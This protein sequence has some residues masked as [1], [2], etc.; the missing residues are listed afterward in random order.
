M[1]FLKQTEVVQKTVVGA[2]GRTIGTVK[3]VAFSLDGRLGLVVSDDDGEHTVPLEDVNGIA[4]YV[5]LK[6]R[7]D[8]VTPTEAARAAGPDKSN[9]VP[10]AGEARA[11]K[12]ADTRTVPGAAT[13]LSQCPKCAKD[14]KPGARFCGRCGHAL[15]EAKA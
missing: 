3:E 2:D 15:Q 5:V 1:T 14:V 11:S 9:A 13:A 6:P 12:A 4:D 10:P 8:H 7:E